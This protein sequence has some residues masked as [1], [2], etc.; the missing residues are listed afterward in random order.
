MA[1]MQGFLGL[2]VKVDCRNL[3][4]FEGQVLNVDGANQIIVLGDGK[5]AKIIPY[6][7]T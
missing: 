7:T 6:L 2:S 1:A 5:K 3:G 4:I